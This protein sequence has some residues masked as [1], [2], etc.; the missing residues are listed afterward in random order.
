MPQ[1]TVQ[2]TTTHFAGLKDDIN[3][4]SN[5]E[6]NIA[7]RLTAKLRACFMLVCFAVFDKI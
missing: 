5:I 4:L 3:K 6:N 2:V 7:P 1:V